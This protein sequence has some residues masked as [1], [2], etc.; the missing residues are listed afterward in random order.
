MNIALELKYFLL[1]FPAKQFMQG[2][3]YQRLLGLYAGDLHAIMNKLII[4]DDIGSFHSKLLLILFYTHYIVKNVYFNS[5][6]QDGED[7]VPVSRARQ[8]VGLDAFV[9]LIYI[10]RIALGELQ[11]P[12]LLT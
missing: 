1:V 9:R 6:Q 3:I 5:A 12:L 10:T 11:L 4:E 8:R 2:M 7:N